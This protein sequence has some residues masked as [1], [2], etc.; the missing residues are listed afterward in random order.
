MYK[1]T[2]FASGPWLYTTNSPVLAIY[3]CVSKVSEWLL[4]IHLQHVSVKGIFHNECIS[5]CQAV[6]QLFKKNSKLLLKLKIDSKS[7][8]FQHR[9]VNMVAASDHQTV[10][11]LAQAVLTLSHCLLPAHT[12]TVWQPLG[13]ATETARPERGFY[14]TNNIFTKVGI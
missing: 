7:K 4:S 9:S 12:H 1:I 8:N 6:K 13:A 11:A 14:N 2:N 5:S 3:K 10:Y